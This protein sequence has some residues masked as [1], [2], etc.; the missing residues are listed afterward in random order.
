[1]TE[2]KNRN[3]YEFYKTPELVIQK[4]LEN[5]KLYGKILDPTAGDGAIPKAIREFGYDN[6]ITTVEIREEEEKKLHVFGDVHI[7]DFLNWQ[8]DQKYDTIITNPPFI[9]AKEIIMKCFEI[10]SEKGQIIML[11][12]TAHLECGDRYN[13]WQN[14][15]VSYLYALS[16]RPHFEDDNET[17]QA[18][19]AWFVWDGT[20]GTIKVI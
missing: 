9:V 18:A 1:M 16:Q 5:R 17:D 4:L 12:K 2:Q 8:P 14:Y 13:F 15:P 7:G 3:K 20:E 6:P 19:Y 10:C 11:L